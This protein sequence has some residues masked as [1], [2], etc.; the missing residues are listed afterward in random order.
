MRFRYESSRQSATCANAWP[1]ICIEAVCN[2]GS[3]LVARADINQ[4]YLARSPD[5][6][7]IE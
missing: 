2:N 7:W 3:V 6:V 4:C 1:M 5:E